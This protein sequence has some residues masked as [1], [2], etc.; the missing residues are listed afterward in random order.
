VKYKDALFANEKFIPGSREKAARGI[1]FPR[2]HYIAGR[3]PKD[4][5]GTKLYRFI[6]VNGKGGGRYP[7]RPEAGANGPWYFEYESFQKMKVFAERYDYP[8]GYA[9][10]LFAAVIFD[11]SDVDCYVVSE[12]TAAKPLFAWK[13]R[14][15]QIEMKHDPVTGRSLADPRDLATMTPMQQQWEVYQLYIPGL[16]F[17]EKE[18]DKWFKLAHHEMVPSGTPSYDPKLDRLVYA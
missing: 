13:G 16:G 11:W 7:G 17:H 12:V 2:E 18:Y 8:L 10:R 15:K 14:G 1:S 3:G 9:A 4:P 6:N 5:Q